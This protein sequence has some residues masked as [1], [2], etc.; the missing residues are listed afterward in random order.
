MAQ[1]VAVDPLVMFQKSGA[2]FKVEEFVE[3]TLTGKEPFEAVV[4]LSVG[5]RLIDLLND[6]RQFIPVKRMDNSTMIMAKSNIISIVEKDPFAKTSN[7]DEETIASGKDVAASFDDD[8]YEDDLND[9]AAGEDH[10]G[11]NGSAGEEDDLPPKADEGTRE[12]QREGAKANDTGAGGDADADDG[13]QRK[14]RRR[15]RKKAPE[16]DAYAILKVSPDATLDEIRTAYK[17]RIKAVHPDSVA[18]LDLD[19][20]LV[21]AAIATTQKVNY[22]YH[23]ILKQRRKDGEDEPVKAA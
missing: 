2:K 4:F 6:Q 5:D 19:P 3:I 8:E 10:Q 13:A 15:R 21:R 14:R 20:E 11:T 17:S 22:A 12:R 9:D 18:A 1:S 23:H 7:M 16:F